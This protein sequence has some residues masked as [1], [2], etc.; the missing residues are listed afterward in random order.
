[1]QNPNWNSIHW[2]RYWNWTLQFQNHMHKLFINN[3]IHHSASTITTIIITSDGHFCRWEFRRLMSFSVNYVNENWMF[4]C[5]NVYCL[6]HNA[7][8]LLKSNAHWHMSQI[9]RWPNL[10]W[11]LIILV[12]IAQLWTFMHIICIVP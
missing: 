8:C 9:D 2:Q 11:I 1:M 5:V 6:K 4:Q 7:I 10:S 3:G 12:R